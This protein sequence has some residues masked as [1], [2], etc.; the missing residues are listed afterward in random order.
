M[1]K[2]TMVLEAQGYTAEYTVTEEDVARITS[3]E[4]KLWMVC[5]CH[6]FFT[7]AEGDNL[8]EALDNAVDEGR[9][10]CVAI[11]EEDYEDMQRKGWDDAYIL[12]GNASEPFDSMIDAREVDKV[13]FIQLTTG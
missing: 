8:E 11:S 5:H 9:M 10:D 2:F 1:R 6:G 12:L 3:W 13:S 7:W 4:Y